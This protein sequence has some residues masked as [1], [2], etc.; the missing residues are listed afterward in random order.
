MESPRSTQK[1][2]KDMQAVGLTEIA[3]EQIW[4]HH[5][6]IQQKSNKLCAS[7]KD[8]NEIH[9]NWWVCKPLKLWTLMRPPDDIARILLWQVKSASNQIKKSCMVEASHA[10][11]LI[12][13]ASLRPRNFVRVPTIQDRD[14]EHETNRP[15]PPICINIIITTT[16]MNGEHGQLCNRYH[17]KRMCWCRKK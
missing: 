8:W 12:Y 11:N 1:F 6:A 10:S 4:K 15:F 17:N 2:S 16:T 3:R 9:L 14:M 5:R 13:N 7:I